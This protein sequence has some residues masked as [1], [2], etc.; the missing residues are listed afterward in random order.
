MSTVKVK[1]DLDW[2]SVALVKESEFLPKD[3]N[4]YDYDGTLV[5]SY[6]ASEFL[7]HNIMPA[8]PIHKGLKAQEWNWSI[9][10]AKAHVSKYGKLDV[11]VTYITDDGK[12]RI[13][14]NIDDPVLLTLRLG[15]SA[16]GS[17]TVDWGDGSS[18][19]V[20]NGTAINIT[21]YTNDHTYSSVGKY[22]ITL[23]PTSG[24]VLSFYHGSNDS[25]SLILPRASY[26][27]S[28]IRRRYYGLVYKLEFGNGIS[29]FV[30][31]GDNAF[32]AF[33]NLETVT[34]P[35]TIVDG[36][37]RVFQ[38]CVR[39]KCIIFARGR[40]NPGGHSLDSCHGLTRAVLSDTMTADVSDSVFVYCKALKNVIIP[41]GVLSLS[42]GCFS[43]TWNIS[44]ITIP[45]SV[46]TISANAFNACSG[47][48]E[49]HFTSATP[50]TVANSNA[51]SSLSDYYKIYVPTG[52]LSSY[53]SA[54]NYPDP[55]TYT[56]IEE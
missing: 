19:E 1:T 27:T 16:V 12:T 21:V 3:V 24:S 53:T 22:V 28:V 54:T 18:T 36:Y 15:F 20:V 52:S 2:Q 45:D 4:F 39:L 37:T 9:E 55:S 8:F 10:N 47:L 13:Y 49:I 30:P 32:R 40:T 41:D 26:G 6:T 50:P 5:H 34:I 51:F 29:A 56:Y 46:T 38:D 25:P 17:I 31:S 33:C 43:Q 14:I 48:H 7:M 44:S 42:S 35:N 11:G 23:E